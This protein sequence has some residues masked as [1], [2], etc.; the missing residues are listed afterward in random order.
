MHYNQIT[1]MWLFYGYKVPSEKNHMSK[2]VYV[3]TLCI[4]ISICINYA[5]FYLFKILKTILLQNN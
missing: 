1:T 5:C 3:D 4:K 2:H